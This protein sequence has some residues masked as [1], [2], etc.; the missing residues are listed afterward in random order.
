MGGVLQS[1]TRH[2]HACAMAQAIENH[3]D[4][5][6][7]HVKLDFHRCSFSTRDCQ[8]Y[9]W[10]YFYRNFCKINIL[11]KFT[12]IVYGCYCAYIHS[13]YVHSW[14]IHSLL[15]IQKNLANHSMHL[16]TV[17]ACLSRAQNV[18]SWNKIVKQSRIPNKS[19]C[20]ALQNAVNWEHNRY[21]MMSTIGLVL[22]IR[23]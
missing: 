9:G 12:R 20:I 10:N 3:T 1:I 14:H 18:S 13:M 17:S 16:S 11:Y 4:N 7:M 6:L 22:R 15:S 23:A 8:I 19:S 21:K 5:G 2:T